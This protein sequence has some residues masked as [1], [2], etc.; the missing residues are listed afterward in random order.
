MRLQ[1]LQYLIISLL[2]ICG[3]DGI[4]QEDKQML[5]ADKAYKVQD[6]SS[7]FVGYNDCLSQDS[8]NMKCVEKAAMSALKL[9][10]FKNRRNYFYS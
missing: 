7:S 5:E 8:T 9:G 6:F 2:L 4:C 10:D 3:F 1:S